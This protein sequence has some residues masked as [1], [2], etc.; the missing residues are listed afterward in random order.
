MCTEGS[1]LSAFGRVLGY[2]TQAVN[3][4]EGLHSVRRDKLN[5]LARRT[6]G[7]AKSMEMLAHSLALVCWQQEEKLNIYPRWE[8]HTFLTH[9]LAYV[10]LA[11]G[12]SRAGRVA[13]AG[14][15][16]SRLGEESPG[17]SGQGAG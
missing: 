17:S 15:L 5:R 8:Y 4:N 1:S 9:I 13:A 6:M 10:S 11:T 3:W 14:R 7:Y 2:S 12:E 16:A